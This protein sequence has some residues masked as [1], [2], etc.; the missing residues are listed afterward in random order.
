M[1]LSFVRKRKKRRHP[2]ALFRQSLLVA[3]QGAGRRDA[4]RVRNI[5]LGGIYISTRD[6][7]EVGTSLQLFF[8]TPEGEVQARA[9]V[10]SMHLGRGMGVEF[11]GMNLHARRRLYQLMKRLLETDHQEALAS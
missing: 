2:R 5:C 1:A 11:L 8:D 9:V 10:R 4:N 3:W 6:P 7:A